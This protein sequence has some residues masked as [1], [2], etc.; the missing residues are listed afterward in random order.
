MIVAIVRS[1]LN[2]KSRRVV[3]MRKNRLTSDHVFQVLAA[4]R[5]MLTVFMG[6]GLLGYL[7]FYKTAG[8]TLKGNS[9]LWITWYLAMIPILLLINKPMDRYLVNKSFTTRTLWAILLT[10]LN[11]T[12]YIIQLYTMFHL[13]MRMTI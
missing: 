4:V 11:S 10:I 13:D 3:A 5:D 8:C 1:Y 7:A 12:V 6:V 9:W 2:I